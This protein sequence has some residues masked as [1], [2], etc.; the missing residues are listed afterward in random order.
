MT[1]EPGR[2]APSDHRTERIRAAVQSLPMFRGLPQ[3]ERE[4]VAGIASMRDL[5]RGGVLWNAGDPADTLMLI[6]SGR[7]KIVRHGAGGDVILEIFGQGEPVG[8]TLAVHDLQGRVLRRVEL[9]A[10]ARSGA[11]DGRD[12]SGSRVPP[13]QYV[14][15][16]RGDGAVRTARVTQVR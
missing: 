8:A 14:V 6:V 15:M 16:L 2:P 10:G 9:P 1:R 11:W 4:R 3:Q 5:A 7:I 12:D 13:G